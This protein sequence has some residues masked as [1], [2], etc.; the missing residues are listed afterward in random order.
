M[1]HIQAILILPYLSNSSLWKFSNFIQV[2]LG[3]N[4]VC[5]S[6]QQQIIELC[7]NSAPICLDL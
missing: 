5:F 4:R 6:L 1:N 3:V 2:W 7:F